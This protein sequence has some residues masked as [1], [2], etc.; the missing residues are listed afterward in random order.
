LQE[1]TGLDRQARGVGE[2][3]IFVEPALEDRAHVRVAVHETR[4]DRLAASVVDVGPRVG[5]E[6][7]VGRTDRHDPV[8]LHCQRDV[9]LNGISVRHSGVGE[10]DRRAR[11]RLCLQSAVIKKEGGG[12]RASA[13]EQFTPADVVRGLRH[14]YLSLEIPD[15][16]ERPVEVAADTVAAN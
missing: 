7:L 3:E 8:P 10:H 16:L 15:F 4:E 5:L 11:R 12:P 1:A 14:R 13:C 9:V 2:A 6:D